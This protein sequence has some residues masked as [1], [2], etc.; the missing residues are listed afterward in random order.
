MIITKI[1]IIMMNF[2]F[3]LNSIIFALVFTNKTLSVAFNEYDY[4]KIY[5]SLI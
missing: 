2:N 1:N 4:K 3:F 5:F